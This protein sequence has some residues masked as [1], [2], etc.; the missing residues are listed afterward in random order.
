VSPLARRYQRRLGG[1]QEKLHERVAE[2]LWVEP[3]VGLFYLTGLE[4]VS[5]ERLF[6]LLVP[7]SGP[8]RMVV[9]L[10]LKDECEHVDVAEQ[11]VWSDAEGPENA[12]A[13]ALEGVSRLLV[14]G[15]LPVWSLRLLETAK[16]G[17]E[18]EEDPSVLSGMRE[19]KEPEEV[20]LIRRSGALTDEA[21]SWVGTLDLENLTER[22]LSGKI[23]ARYLELGHRPSPHGLIATGSNTAMPHYVGGDVPIS[24]AKLLLMDF[25]CAVDGYWSDITRIYFP[26]DLEEEVEEAY[27]VVCEAYDAAFGVLEPGMPCREVDRAAREVIENAGYGDAFLHRTGHGL[28][29]EVH[30]EPYLRDGNEKPLEVGHV[31]SVEPGIY[32]HGRFGVRY[33]NIVHLGADGPEPM[34]LSPRKHYFN[35]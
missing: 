31:F 9:P 4:P 3:S 18:V 2:A 19:R 11:V 12:A 34:N 24:T 13:T 5:M 26:R 32:L 23:Q 20:E 8:P 22:Q 16:P 27:Q 30:E 7:T 6:G 14:Q 28:G 35:T 25:G 17:L 29:L 1:L 10:L 15:S 21:V 33:E